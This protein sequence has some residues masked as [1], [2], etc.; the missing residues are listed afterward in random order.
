MGR[1][2][3]K[4]DDVDRI[5]TSVYVTNFPDNVSA[6][7]LFLACKQYG[8]VVDSYIPVKKSK[9]GKR[10]GFVKFINVFSEERLLRI[11]L[12]FRIGRVSDSIRI[13]LDSQRHQIR[14]DDKEYHSEDSFEASTRFQQPS[15]H[16]RENDTSEKQKTRKMNS[17][18]EAGDVENLK[19]SAKGHNQRSIFKYLSEIPKLCDPC[20]LLE[21]VI[22][23]GTGFMGV[24]MEGFIADLERTT[25][26]HKEE[27]SESVGN[28]GVELMGKNNEIIGVYE[29]PQEGKEKQA[30]WDFRYVS[31]LDKLENGDVIIHGRF[32]MSNK[33]FNLEE[34]IIDKMLETV[35]ARWNDKNV[36]IGVAVSCYS[37]RNMVRCLIIPHVTVLKIPCSVI[38]ILEYLRSKSSM[39]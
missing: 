31:R 23:V 28:S 22:K 13:S 27:S 6:K 7:E 21:D 12:L 10:F 18:S 34:D 32:L 19:G 16:K 5:S 17:P 35:N 14:L 39:S 8:H 20:G 3:T 24:K 38:Q 15:T 30:L 25:L 2:T 4:E 37:N 9:Y 36:S 1:Y 11:L 33:D 26:E 29:A